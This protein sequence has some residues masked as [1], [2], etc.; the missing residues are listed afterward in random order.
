MKKAQI[1]ERIYLDANGLNKMELDILNRRHVE[2]YALIRQWCYG[3]VIDISC[4]CGYGTNLI[5]RNPDVK[6]I[7]G[8]DISKDAIKWAKENFKNDKCNFEV[9]TIEDYN[10]KKDV[11][12]SIETIEHLRNPKILNDLA[13]RCGVKTIFISY[14]SKKTTHYNKYHFHDFIDDDLIRIFKNFKLKNTIELHKEVKILKFIKN[15]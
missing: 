14:P 7:I 4:G 3:E 15:V 2:R 12:I 10:K 9:N 5:S 8:V 11:L 6:N 13:E 1:R